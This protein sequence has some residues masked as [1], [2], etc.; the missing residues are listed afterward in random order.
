MAVAMTTR[1]V[2]GETTTRTMAEGSSYGPWWLQY[3][4]VEQCRSPDK[5]EGGRSFFFL[6]IE[7]IVGKRIRKCFRMLKRKLSL[8]L[9]SG[10][11]ILWTET[12]KGIAGNISPPLQS[13]KDL[14][15]NG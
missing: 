14:L 10:P 5:K 1:M 2:V 12:R 4:C 8:V 7:N 13:H 3:I 11:S 15:E 9:Q 6:G